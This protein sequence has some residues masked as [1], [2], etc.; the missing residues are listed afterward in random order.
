[1]TTVAKHEMDLT[2]GS[3]LKKLIRFAIPIIL[4]N[5]L[6]MLFNVTDV[7]ILGILV[8]DMEVGAVGATTALISLIVNLFIGFSVGTNV[9]LAKCVG[10]H[11]GKKQIA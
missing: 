3:I 7:A 9:V 10:S 6:Q 11:D 5:M 8:G 1:M 2:T 4:M